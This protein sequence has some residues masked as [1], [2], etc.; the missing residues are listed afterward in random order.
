MHEGGDQK[1]SPTLDFNG[2]DVLS[3]LGRGAKGVVFLVRDDKDNKLLALKVILREAIEKTKKKN[4]EYKRV[5]FEQEVLSR[6]DHPLFPSLHGV[7]STDKVIGYAIDYCP[8]QN[9]N[10]LRKMQSESMFSDEIIR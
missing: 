6:F 8:G 3:L 10:S 7:L 5:S 4:D 2:L 9:L 1:Q